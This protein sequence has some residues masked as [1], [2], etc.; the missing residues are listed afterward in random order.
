MQ[1][2]RLRLGAQWKHHSSEQHRHWYAKPLPRRSPFPH[3]VFSCFEQLVSCALS[4]LRTTA[5]SAF[6]R[7]RVCARGTNVHPSSEIRNT[8]GRLLSGPL[9]AFYL[10]LV[11]PCVFEHC[12]LFYYSEFLFLAGAP[13]RLFLT[14][15]SVVSHKLFPGIIWS[16]IVCGCVS[17][18][19]SK[20]C[21]THRIQ[22]RKQSMLRVI[23][24]MVSTVRVAVSS[25]SMLRVI[26]NMACVW[27]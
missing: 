15:F 23:I 18:E 13:F 16:N 5:C 1:V 9:G 21:T 2:S 20:T 11:S 6:A 27:L 3:I 8:F 7:L 12:V 17:R 19:M 14:L 10:E 24:N 25:A 4:F 26:I 22:K